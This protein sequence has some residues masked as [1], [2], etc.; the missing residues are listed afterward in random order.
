MGFLK[1]FDCGLRLRGSKLGRLRRS[2]TTMASAA[3]IKAA[4]RGWAACVNEKR[5]EDL[6]EYMCAT[7]SQNGTDYTPGSWAARVREQVA[8]ALGGD[9]RIHED[10]IMVDE[11]AQ[12]AALSM[13]FRFRPRRPLLGFEP[14][15]RDVW[16]VQHGVVWLADGKLS[17]ALFV[18]NADHMRGQLAS[19]AKAAEEGEDEDE[20]DEGGSERAPDLISECPA[21]K[22]GEDPAALSRAGLEAAYRGYV[23]MVNGRRTGA[24][25]GDH[26]NEP[27]S[28]RNNKALARRVVEDTLAAIPDLHVRIHTLVAD[29]PSQRVAVWLEFAGTP[30]RDYAGL[31]A[32]GR[33]VEFVEHATYQYRGGKIQRIWGVMDL[34]AARQRQRREKMDTVEGL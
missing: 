6:P 27:D 9:V 1:L 7:Y 18:V 4:I 21:P 24:E 8:P 10:S 5:W 31:V 34:E 22:Q 16:L 30:V 13:W 19:A 17:R 29:A 23:D 14:T 33:P 15:G 12:C 11:E 20:D 3:E 28:A 2:R 32:D 26:V 25:Y